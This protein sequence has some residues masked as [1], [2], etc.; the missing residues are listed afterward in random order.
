MV[1]TSKDG[2]DV[3]KIHDDSDPEDEAAAAA[4]PIIDTPKRLQDRPRRSMVMMR[5]S[6]AA[7]STSREPLFIR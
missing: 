4:D 2:V 5:P 6:T 7:A 3:L 1:S